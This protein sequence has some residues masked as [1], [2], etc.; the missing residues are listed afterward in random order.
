MRSLSLSTPNVEW[1]TLKLSEESYG[2]H[3]K[4]EKEVR[5]S[6]GDRSCLVKINSWPL[7]LHEI[8][9]LWTA[10]RRV[11]QRHI[12][13]DGRKSLPAKHLM[14][15]NLH[16]IQRT[17]NIFWKIMIN[18]WATKMNRCLSKGENHEKKKVPPHS[19]QKNVNENCIKILYSPLSEG[20][21]LGEICWWRCR[22]TKTFIYFW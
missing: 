14:V 1:E 13:Y 5:T 17:Q 6:D 18:K 7:G 22:W 19:Y 11:E 9:K 21:T 16:N 4:I 10:K 20:Q 3:A 12:L 8:K 2:K 15:T